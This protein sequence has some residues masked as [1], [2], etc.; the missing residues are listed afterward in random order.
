MFL[1]N[2]SMG[3][4]KWSNASSLYMDLTNLVTWA[5]THGTI[6]KQIPA[7]E[8]VQN[9]A[10]A[11]KD[12]SVLWICGVGHAYHWQCEKLY[13]RSREESKAAERRKRSMSCETSAREANLNEKRFRVT[14][15]FEWGKDAVSTRS[16]SRSPGGT[17]Q[18]GDAVYV[19]HSEPSP[20]ENLKAGKSMKSGFAEKHQFSVSAGEAHTN[21]PKVKQ[22]SSKDLQIISDE[23]QYMSD[24]DDQEDGINQNVLSEPPVTG[25]TA[26]VDSQ[27]HHSQNTAFNKPTATR[28]PGFTPTGKLSPTLVCILKSPLSDQ[29]SLDSSF[30]RLGSPLHPAGSVMEDSRARNPSESAMLKEHVRSVPA[31]NADAEAHVE[32]PASVA[33]FEFEASVDIQQELQLSPL[34]PSM[35]GVDFSENVPDSPAEESETLRSVQAPHPSGSLNPESSN[36]EQPPAAGGVLKT[37]K[38]KNRNSGDI[39]VFKDWLALHCPLE[40]REAYEL[41]PQD[42]DNYLALFYSSAKRQNGTDFSPCSLHF[43]Q[44]AIER[45]LKDHSYKYSVVR[46][47]EFRA[48]QEALKLKHQHLSQKVREGAWSILEKLTDEDVESL[49]K[50]GLL[51][52]NH[53]QALLHLMFTNII[54]GFGARTHAQS[55]SPYW[56]QLVL[57][58]KEGEPEYLEWKD[59]LNMELSTGG[60]GPHLFAKPDDPDNCPVKNYKEYT[61]RRPLDMLHDHDPLYLAPKPLCS[62]WDQVW[63]CRKPLTKAK[64]E[65]MLKIIIQQ[66][67][68]PVKSRK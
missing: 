34:E 16:C 14:P 18:K 62:I 60:S 30:L 24:A 38:K 10:H 53:P 13:I 40:T 39:K 57:K 21:R 35:T 67:K 42:L 58:R 46:G 68:R 61:K 52:K 2:E 64:M 6:C 48:S 47:P 49:W 66:V 44:S 12:N 32:S 20:T 4:G 15:S 23:E 59:N 33:F 56:G 31:S 36:T 27:M 28:R 8:I 19:T 7:L 43:F 55:H 22:E 41:P 1:Q 25:G 50:K 11:S 63:Y 26:E 17:Q 65:K 9:V 45:Y 3:D 5:H 51:G 37:E 54:R 29:G